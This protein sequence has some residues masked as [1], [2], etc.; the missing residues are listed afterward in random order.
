MVY[1]KSKSALFVDVSKRKLQAE[2]AA[3]K[4]EGFFQLIAEN[5]GDFISVLDL[6]GQ[7]VYA[8]PSY[9]QILGA[10]R[11]L[12]GSDFFAEIHPKDKA[13][14]KQVFHET[15]LTGIGRQ[16]HYRML[17]ADGTVR[18]MESTG[19]VIRDSLGQ[20]AQVVVVSRDVTER[21]CREERMLQ[22]AS[23]DDL[24][25]LPNRR[26]LSDR[27][28]QAMAASARDGSYAAL[29]FL[30]LDHFKLLNDTH[31]HQYGDLLLIEVANRL[32][33]CVRETDTVA[34]FGGDEY[35]VVI[36][37][38]D[39]AYAQSLSLVAAVAEKI[40]RAIVQPFLLKIEQ[41]DSAPMTI[42]YQCTASIGIV[43]FIGHHA[44]QEHILKWADA[45]MYEAKADGR[46]RI[47]FYEAAP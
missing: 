33:N 28:Q 3:K 25:Q 24:T 4:P 20:I 11:D 44:T 19:N 2:D 42:E 39:A 40:Q 1:S 30:D 36:N 13:R 29:M 43:L 5:I 18:E 38:L 6:D 14:V 26:L 27:L 34:R 45:A 15:V 37:E 17:V 16:I 35:V 12:R 7:R 32:T 23:H 46:N 21:R 10:E 41:Q 31:G 8:S 9:A 47:R 22:L